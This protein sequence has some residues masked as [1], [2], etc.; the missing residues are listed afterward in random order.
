MMNIVSERILATADEA[1]VGDG[2]LARKHSG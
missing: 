1:L 2:P